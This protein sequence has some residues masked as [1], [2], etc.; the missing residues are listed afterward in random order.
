MMI[1][2]VLSTCVRAAMQATARPKNCRLN[3]MSEK[4]CPFYIV[5][6]HIKMDKTSRTYSKL[7][8]LYSQA[9]IILYVLCMY[10]T[11]KI[12]ILFLLLISLS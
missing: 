8:N 2:V 5:S 3:R 10:F 1:A 12:W 6:C 7:D 9:W 11:L 4:P